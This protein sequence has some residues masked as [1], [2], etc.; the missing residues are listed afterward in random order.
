M[1]G[2]EEKKLNSLHEEDSLYKAQGGKAAYQISPTYGQN[3]L[4]KVNPVHDAWD[5][6]L[7]AESICQDILVQCQKPV[8][9][10]YA[11]YG[12]RIVST[13]LSGRYGRS[14]CWNG[15]NCPVLSAGR[16]DGTVQEKPGKGE[17]NLSSQPF[18]LHFSPLFSREG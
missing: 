4:Y 17:S 8:V 16:T 2:S 10:E 7:A 15:W 13:F 6:A 3:T 9:P 11:L 14:S 1:S 12:L 5:R 18:T